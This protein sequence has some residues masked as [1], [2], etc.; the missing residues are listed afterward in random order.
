MK[1]PRSTRSWIAVFLMLAAVQIGAQQSTPISKKLTFDQDP[2]GL[3]P[4]G[5]AFDRTGEGPEGQ[6]IVRADPASHKNHILVQESHDRT[7][8]RYPLAIANEG[9]HRDVALSVRAK[10][11][12]GERDQGF[13]LVW[14]YKDARNYYVA[15]CN[16]NEDNCRIYRIVNGTRQLFQD[17]SVPVAKNTWHVL[18]VEA[19]GDHFVVWFDGMKVL[20]AV[21]DTFKDPGRVG[22]WTKA[23]SVIQFDDLTIE[24]H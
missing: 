6:W 4:A 14:R 3:P 10:P 1:S 24:G 8:Y 22:L 13:G 23:D 15:R 9:D 7:D 20:D 2:V 21:D 17:K 19:T 18:K 11:I 12:S 16:A 5:F